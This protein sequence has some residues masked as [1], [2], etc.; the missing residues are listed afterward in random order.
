M[1]RG[2]LKPTVIGGRRVRVSGPV[3]LGRQVEDIEPKGLSHS[4]EVEGI[5]REMEEDLRHGVSPATINA[6]TRILFHA[7]KN[8]GLMSRAE[9]VKSVRLILR[10]RAEHGWRAWRDAIKFLREVE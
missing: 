10:F 3:Y 4:R 7:V 5:L 9:K 1:G 6:R 2:R 8:S